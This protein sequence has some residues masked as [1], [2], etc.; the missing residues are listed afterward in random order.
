TL[1]QDERYKV[2]TAIGYAIPAD[3]Y[4]LDGT[5]GFG[6]RNFQKLCRG[7][8]E[9][10]KRDAGTILATRGIHRAP[11]YGDRGGV[12]HEGALYL[13]GSVE[14]ALDRYKRYEFEA[15][16][17]TISYAQVLVKK[18]EKAKARE[19]LREYITSG[20]EDIAAYELLGDL[21]FGAGNHEE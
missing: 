7:A 17:G 9:T 20:Q 8:F 2:H 14:E 13:F 19:Y 15:M 16:D 12:I 5:I 18:G 4:L 11:E 10:R 1:A 21:A 6:D 3:F